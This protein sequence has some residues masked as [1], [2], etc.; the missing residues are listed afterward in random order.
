MRLFLRLEYK[1]KS[2]A[3]YCPSYLVR[4]PKQRNHP[5]SRPF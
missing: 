1:Q 2:Y 4:V 5:L 3:D